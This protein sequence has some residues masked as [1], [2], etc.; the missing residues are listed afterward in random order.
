MDCIFCCF[1]CESYKHLLLLFVVKNEEN[2]LT[3][4]RPAADTRKITRSDVLTNIFM[5]GGDV[6]K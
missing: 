3:K 5:G 4:R 1:W 2:V 6:A